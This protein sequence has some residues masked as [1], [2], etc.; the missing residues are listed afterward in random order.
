L[1]CK[2]FEVS[3]SFAL[4]LAGWRDDLQPDEAARLNADLVSFRP[5]LSLQWEVASGS[6]STDFQHLED[7]TG[8]INLDF[9]PVYIEQRPYI[10][11]RQMTGIELFEYMRN[12]LDDFFD[13]D[14]G[15]FTHHH[16]EEL[17]KWLSADPLGATMSFQIDIPWVPFFDEGMSVM[18][19]NVT[20]TSWT[21]STISTDEDASH[22]VNGNREFGIDIQSGGDLLY[23]RGA[24]RA[25][26]D[27][28][29]SEE[30][31]FAG[32]HDFWLGWQRGV[33]KFIEDHGGQATAGEPFS[34]RL[35]WEMVS[36]ESFHPTVPW[37]EIGAPEAFAMNSPRP[38][39]SWEAF[40]ERISAELDPGFYRHSDAASRD[41]NMET[42]AATGTHDMRL[43][44]P[45][46]AD[47]SQQPF[48]MHSDAASRDFNMETDAATGT[49]DM[50]LDMPPDADSSQQPFDMHSD[51]AS[52]DFNMETDAATGT[53][54][55]RL[56][57]PPDAE[58]GAVPAG[59]PSTEAGP[60]QEPVEPR[61]EHYVDVNGSGADAG[62]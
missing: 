48:D 60:A 6:T 46:D 45:P 2:G 24:D 16:R 56:D 13:H 42:D 23:T 39:E 1:E 20:A 32:G 36:E 22:P 12:H 30:T 8:P 47:S 57:M 17:Q 34:E 15:R 59:V 5:P 53:H 21:F 31:V 18:V 61:P 29:I 9:Y 58:P 14:E 33:V 51:A 44:M 50:R 52:R 55:M 41:F 54:G 40:D 11:G 3:N 10:D 4:P 43:D 25:A 27:F 38:S 28:P 37:H 26:S 35:P 62:G 7:G 49:H 19:T